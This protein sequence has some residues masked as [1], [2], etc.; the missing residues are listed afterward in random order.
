MA[1]S[2]GTGQTCGIGGWGGPLPGDPDNN[3]LLSAISAFGGIDVS[4]T[5]PSH[6]PFAVAHVLLYRGTVNS[7]G[8]A[9]QI[10]TVAGDRFYDKLEDPTRY[11]Y[12]IR[13]VSVNGTVGDVIGPA[14]AVAKPTITGMIEL[15]TGQIDAGLLAETLKQD[16]D[17]ISI[18]N[19]NL[20]D[21]IVARENGEVTLAEAME[22]V[23]AG[24][25]EA[26]TF[27]QTE[28]A[29]RVSADTAIAEQLTIVAATLGGDLA[30][31]T[32]QMQVSIDGLTGD[33]SAIYGAKVN[34]NGL[35]GGFGIVNDGAS[36]EAG[37][38]VDT[39]WVGRTNADKRKPFIIADGVTYIDDAA[40]RSLTFNKLRDE[41]GTFIVENGKIKANYLQVNYLSALTSSLGQVNITGAP[42]GD[43]SYIRTPGKWLDGTWGYIMA[44]HP[45]GSSF[46]DFTI[47][48]CRFYM[49]HNAGISA[50]MVMDTP[51]LYF[52]S[53]GSMSVR[54]LNVIGTANINGN[55][56]TIPAYTE[57][58]GPTVVT[59]AGPHL[60][61]HL[62]GQLNNF[63]SQGANIMML[64]TFEQDDPSIRFHVDIWRGA[65]TQVW[66][67]TTKGG[68]TA[69]FGGW[70][71]ENYFV[72][73]RNANS[74]L[75]N[76]TVR[77][78]SIFALALR[79]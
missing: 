32:T 74:A 53:N 5:Y 33:I 36:V 67:G 77:F 72:Y 45:N 51:G 31:V 50:T 62:L 71:N 30:A 47:G 70:S 8:A 78:R 9:M 41:Q 7:F 64:L 25:A 14:S 40:I 52:D 54:A 27:I 39:F 75:S 24:V 61:R 19:Q 49:H 44:Q 12:W 68:I 29:S 13:I 55:A 58:G 18:L 59:P 21:E 16:L 60:G 63:D 6:N 4:W 1:T 57:G 22:Q 38:D 46:I 73:A 10:A 48:N 66:T 15:L 23:D 2:P 37:F 76:A 11:Y 56:V 28:I 43:W 26:L 65:S 17:K 34:V 35:I 20:L 79:R 3:S 69:F 42:G